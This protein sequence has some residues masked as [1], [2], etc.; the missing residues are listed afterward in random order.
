MFLSRLV[1]TRNALP[2]SQWMPQLIL[3]TSACFSQQLHCL[4][5]HS[6]WLETPPVYHD[7]TSL[8]PPLLQIM[9]CLRAPLTDSR[10]QHENSCPKAGELPILQPAPNLPKDDDGAT[11]PHGLVTGIRAAIRGQTHL[12]G[13][14]RSWQLA[15]TGWHAPWRGGHVMRA[16]APPIQ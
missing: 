1:C 12:H 13:P 2:E 9:L 11:I 8:H 15:P 7:S 3:N 4:T 6:P 14:A 16:V 10:C 5:Q